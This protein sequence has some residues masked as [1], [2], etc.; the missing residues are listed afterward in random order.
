MADWVD[1][2]GV[3]VPVE[4][5]AAR[6]VAATQRIASLP[7]NF[8]HCCQC[9]CPAPAAALLLPQKKRDDYEERQR[10]NDERRRAH[11][12]ARRGEEE[13]KREEERR[14]EE[15]RAAAYDEAQRR[16]QAR[17]DEVGGRAAG[18]GCGGQ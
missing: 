9:F 8:S 3:G 17:V 4:Q 7:Q 5:A 1:G 12:A 6:C 16:E 15:Q 18:W 14:K 2:V 10:Q 11:E 13:A